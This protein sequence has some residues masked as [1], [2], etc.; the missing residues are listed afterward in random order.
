MKK[1]LFLIVMCMFGLSGLK[2][3]DVPAAPVITAEQMGVTIYIEWN[4][5]EDADYYKLYYSGQFM[6]D[7]NDTYAIVPTPYVG[8]FCFKVTAVNEAGESEYS[9]EECVTVVVPEGLEKPSAP[10]LSVKVENDSIVVS[11][12]RVETAMYY[13]IYLDGMLTQQVSDPVTELKAAPSMPETYC[14]TVTAVNLAGE[15]AHSNE[16]CVTY[17]EDG[18][19]ENVASFN[20]YPNP[21]NDKL[22]IETEVEVEEVVVYAITGVIVGQQSTVNSQQSVTIDVTNLNSGVYFVKVVTENGESVQRFIK[23]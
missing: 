11:W 17:P 20:I 10:V 19:E 22:Y 2:A 23:K 18:I 4:A 14:F 12:E 15:S 8:E 16:V 5:V 3:Q 21:V 9:N 6:G 13:M 1:I 7:V